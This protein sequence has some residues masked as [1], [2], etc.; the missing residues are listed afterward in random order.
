MGII[1]HNQGKPRLSC[2]AADPL[3]HRFLGLD[4][5]VLQL[6][7]EIVLAE[8]I[9]KLQSIGFRSVIVVLH[10]TPGDGTCQAGGQGD[11]A[12]GMPA[13]QSQ[14]HSG[15]SVEAPQ[16]SGGYQA[17]QIGVA[18]HILAQK[19]QMI[20]LVV[21]A[22]DMVLHTPGRNVDLTADDGL[23]PGCL[24]GFIK[25]DDAVHNAVIRDCNGSLPHGFDCF[26][27]LVYAAGAVKETVFG[28]KMKMS[29]GQALTAFQE[30][31]LP[32]AFQ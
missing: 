23:H 27:K 21:D 22:V 19:D 4:A 32:K 3:I 13:Q 7:K 17:G 18:L 20:R 30:F 24:G 8:N 6:Q 26:N 10:Q 2:Q 28:M 11:E 1:G 12:P 9:R 31:I 16:E 15:L 5:V 14:V 25:I 29:K